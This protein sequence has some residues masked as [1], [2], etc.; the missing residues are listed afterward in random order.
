MMEVFTQGTTS[1][2]GIPNFPTNAVA[3]I[4]PPARMYKEYQCNPPNS[5]WPENWISA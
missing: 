4:H 2:G 5:C 3:K 1:F